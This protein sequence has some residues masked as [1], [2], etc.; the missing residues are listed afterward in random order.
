MLNR[1]LIHSAPRQTAVI[2]AFALLLV[3]AALLLF[4]QSPAEAQGN[5]KATSNLA[6][7]SPHPG[8][9]VITWDAPSDVPDDYRV[10]WKK[11]TAKWP[12]YKNDN[13]VE[14]GNAF[15]TGT[16]H[17]VSDLEEGTEYH[18]RV[19]ARYYNGNGDVE[20]SGQWSQTAPITI[21]SSPPA[22]PTGL[23]TSP[24][25]DSV[26]LSWTDPSDNGITGYQVLR[27][28]D[29]ANLTVL[30]DNTGSAATSYTDDT[31]TAETTYVYA[32]R[33]RNAHGLSPQS[34]GVSAVTP[35]APEPPAKPTGLSTTPSHDKVVLTWSD[36]GDSNIT[37]Y[38]VLRGPDADNLAVLV[39][40]TGSSSLSYTDS[41]VAAET[42]YAYAIKARNTGGLSPQVDA[43]PVTTPAA[44]VLPA[45]PTGLLAA[46]THSTVLL[47]W[48]NPNDDTITGY[49]ILRGP[50]A[51]NLAVLTTDTGN[52]S[53]EYTDD[54]VEPATQYFYSVRARNAE[55]LSP[56]SDPI[57]V[58]THAAPPEPEI[59]LATATG[60]PEIRGSIQVGATLSVDTSDIEDA[61]GITS[62]SYSYQWIRIDTDSTETNIST[63]ST[64]TLTTDDEGKT[65]KVKVSFTD[66]ASNAEEVESDATR[67]VAARTHITLVS[68]LGQGG[69][70]APYSGTLRQEFTTGDDPKGY[71]IREARI[72]L[73]GSSRTTADRFEAAIYE[74]DGINLVPFQFNSIG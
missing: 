66:D 70:T 74:K 73:N 63:D 64:Y 9:L 15:P 56:Q 68:N 38:Q 7:S 71:L 19:R 67:T 35:A 13:T 29:A 14:G 2:T 62:A 25:H 30:T 59:A 34:D 37:S 23:S 61:D 41:T 40:N 46:T 28:P 55:G 4:L 60:Q 50:D 33:A 72:V 11:S 57:S 6:L 31:V 17:T 18:V 32:I 42:T 54:T 45:K 20:Q 36:P 21:S 48:T 8:E 24:S 47:F 53:T 44:P 1:I 52:T 12:S 5:D 22:K 3:T 43:V 16:S 39:D 49:Q 10:T 58:T 69:L 65:I 26:L 51:A 27:G